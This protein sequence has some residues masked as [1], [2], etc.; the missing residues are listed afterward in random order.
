MDLKESDL[1]CDEIDNHWYYSS[2]AYALVSYISRPKFF[3]V[4]DV[5]S[6]SGFFSKFLLQNT[7]I[8]DAYCYD[9]NYPKSYDIEYFGKKIYFRNSIDTFDADLILMMDVLEHIDDDLEFLKIFVDGAKK[10]T[11]FLI[12]V[13]AFMFL[14]SQHDVFLEHKRRYQINDLNLLV[15]DSGLRVIKSTYFYSLV[16]PIAALI[17][18]TSRIFKSSHVEAKSNLKKHSPLTNLFLK[19]LCRIDCNYI[20]NRNKIFGLSIFCLAEK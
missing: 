19:L 1:I 16:F 12:S 7:N 14:W 13:P 15:E 3:R 10:G 20:F 6:G 4:L 9:I 17:R 11:Q 2:K 18:L 8:N 5:G